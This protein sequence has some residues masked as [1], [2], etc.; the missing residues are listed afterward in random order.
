MHGGTINNL[1]IHV[2]TKLILTWDDYFKLCDSLVEQVKDVGFTDIV[3]ISRGGLIPS[4]YIAY[5][6]GIKRIHNFGI[7][8]YSDNN[9]QLDEKLV[10]IYQG[11]TTVFDRDNKVLIVDDIADTGRTLKWCQELQPLL[12]GAA[13]KK[14]ATLQYKPETSQIRPDYFAQ[15]VE[16]SQWVVYPYDV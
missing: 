4:Q 13:I 7:Q 12:D 5:K 15:A 1:E 10:I 14:T 16:R 3:A 6:L 8:S 11:V 2:P 9:T